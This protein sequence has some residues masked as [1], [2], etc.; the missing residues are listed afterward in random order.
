MHWQPSKTSKYTFEFGN[1]DFLSGTDILAIGYT[2]S[3]LVSPMKWLDELQPATFGRGKNPGDVFG[4][5]ESAWH[6]HHSQRAGA[7]VICS[8]R[9]HCT[10]PR[11]GR[12]QSADNG[13]TCLASMPRFLPSATA[14]PP[15]CMIAVCGS[16]QV[17]ISGRLDY[18]NVMFYG[19]S[20]TLFG[21]LQSNSHPE[22]SCSFLVRRSETRRHFAGFQATSLVASATP[23]RV[24][25]DRP[26][27]Q[28]A[29]PRPNSAVAGGGMP[30]THRLDNFYR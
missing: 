5:E 8:C 15:G 23:S 18:C 2:G 12:W 25:A 13:C 14:A 19:I 29:K 1:T 22:C 20:D 24:P 7:V 28:V 3:R 21:R 16:R 30:T 9:C 10:W 27:T 11:R 26:G 6:N 17:F 4:I